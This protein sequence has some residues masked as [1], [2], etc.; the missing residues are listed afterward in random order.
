[1]LPRRS[2][3]ELALQ[4]EDNLDLLG[5]DADL[6]TVEMMQTHLK[7]GNYGNA[8]FGPW[9]VGM[10]SNKHNVSYFVAP[11]RSPETLKKLIQEHAEEDSTIH[12]DQWEATSSELGFLCAQCRQP[13]GKLRRFSVRSSHPEH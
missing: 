9:I 8:V 1:M 13:F 12:A 7:N 11:D 6:T 10:Y 5:L 3:Q 4:L 2:F